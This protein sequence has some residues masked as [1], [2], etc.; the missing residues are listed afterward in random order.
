MANEVLVVAPAQSNRRSNKRQG[1]FDNAEPSQKSET[2][3]CTK[4]GHNTG[5][6][7]T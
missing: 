7:H 1:D 5:A 4:C 3:K 2:V 6:S